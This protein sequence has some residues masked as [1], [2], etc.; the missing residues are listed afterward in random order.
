LFCLQATAQNSTDALRYSR[1]NYSGTARFSAM[2]GS[3]GALGGEISSIL[4]NPAA[5]GVYRSSEFT[6]SAG[7]SDFDLESSFKGNSTDQSEIQF[8]IPNIGYVGSYKGN[9]DG[10]KNYSFAIQFNRINDFNKS[11]QVKG[12]SPNASVINDYVDELNN[13]DATVSDVEDFL[14]PFGPSEAWFVLL[15]DTINNSSNQTNFVPFF[16]NQ[17]NIEHS[18]RVESSGSQSETSFSFGGNYQDRLYLGGSINFQRIR[19]EQTTIIDETYTY[20]PPA[21]AEDSVVTNYSERQFLETTG[22]GVNLKIG[23]I[24]RINDQFRVGAN[25]HSPT[26]FGMNE[27]FIFES[28]SRFSDGAEFDSDETISTF[29]YRLRTPTRFGLSVA[30]LFRQMASFNIDYEYVDYSSSELN[31]RGSTNFD[32]SQS[33][34]GIERNLDGAHHIRIGSEIKFNPFVARLGFRYEENPL[35][36]SG[37]NENLERTS[38]SLGGGYRNKNFNFD[39]AYSIS[40]M[41]VTDPLFR[42][43]DAS[44]KIEERLYRI[45]ATVGWRW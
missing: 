6:L 26:F 45:V 5:V 37:F 16:F 17:E 40:S 22:N 15:V 34:E 44:A 31:D 30:Y 1:L 4:I 25:I 39:L 19:F 3:F 36:N 33:N 20:D 35:S 28:S 23:A 9:P 14:F 21:I 2:G 42:T 8:V 43:S 32:F 27:Q 18:Q 38:Y 13:S 7:F 24:Y 41:D 11:Y 12:N 10:W 29:E